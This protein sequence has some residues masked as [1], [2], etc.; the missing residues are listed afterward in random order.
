MEKKKS[1]QFAIIGALSFAVLFMSV[2]FATYSQVIDLKSAPL[3]KEFGVTLD[4]GSYQL[5]EGS[6]KAK[7]FSIADNS[8]DFSAHLDKPGDY[9]LFSIKAVNNGNFDGVL[10]NVWMTTPDA[11]LAPLVDYT[12]Y[13]NNEDT[14]TSSEF[15]LDYAIN[16]NP[17]INTKTIIV[18]VLYNPDE[19]A[20]IPAEGVDFDFNLMLD[21]I[22]TI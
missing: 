12:V 3:P 22:Q 5:G 4:E 21:Y 8:I 16:K 1:I 13:Y 11:K 14:F 2:G 9:F 19:D 10:D 20:K 15:D 17:G 18:K 7:S 6:V